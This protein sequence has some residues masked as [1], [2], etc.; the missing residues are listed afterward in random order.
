M[1]FTITQGDQEPFKPWKPQLPYSGKTNRNQN[2]R[3]QNTP[4][5]TDAGNDH[6]L[7]TRCPSRICSSTTSRRNMTRTKSW[8][9]KWRKCSNKIHSWNKKFQGPMRHHQRNLKRTQSWLWSPRR[10]PHTCLSNTATEQNET[11]ELRISPHGESHFSKRRSESESRNKEI[12]EIITCS[13]SKE[14]RSES[15]SKNESKEKAN[16]VKAIN[17]PKN[18]IRTKLKGQQ[19]KVRKFQSL[20]DSI[21]KLSFHQ[22]LTATFTISILFFNSVVSDYF[23]HHFV[24]PLQICTSEKLKDCENHFILR[25][26]ALQEKLTPQSLNQQDYTEILKFDQ[27]YSLR[28]CTGTL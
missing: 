2:T 27:A 15:E 7:F 28:I 21:L 11:Q 18:E 25:M 10:W 20:K 5:E 16:R 23:D 14:T 13:K 8:G 26:K 22:Y 19:D 12:K 3:F 1:N 4:T 24:Y 17:R 9:T 6:Q